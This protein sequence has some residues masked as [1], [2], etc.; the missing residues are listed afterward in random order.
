[1]TCR[2][3][4]A[5]YHRKVRRQ[6]SPFAFVAVM[7]LV[8]PALIASQQPAV[9]IGVFRDL[10]WRLLGPFRG[11]RTTTIAGV[12]SQPHTFYAGTANGGVWRTTDAGATW[13]PIFDG[14]T[15]GSIG[16]I[17][18]APSDPNVIYVGTGASPIHD[19]AS[20][21]D[22]LYRSSD[23]GRSWSRLGLAGEPH[24]SGIIVDPRSPDRVL[25]ASAGGARTQSGQRG[26]Y[27]STNG[28]KSFE[29]VFVSDD[30]IGALDLAFD[31]G[32]SSIVY[33]TL[34]RRS[35]N[36]SRTSAASKAAGVIKSSDGGTTWSPASAGLPSFETDALR[37]VRL[38]TTVANR[39]RLYAVADA[40]DRSGVYRTDDGAGT[41]TRVHPLPASTGASGSRALAV[42]PANAD[43]V[44]LLGPEPLRSIDAGRSFGPWPWDP[45]AGALHAVWISPQQPPLIAA[46]GEHGA[47]VTLNSGETWSS[48]HNQPTGRFVDV[49]ADNAF[50]YRVCATS[51]VSPPGCLPSR[52][53]GGRIVA[54]DWRAVS[55]SIAGAVAPD[56]QDADLVYTGS[57][58]RFDRRTGQSQH[59]APVAEPGDRPHPTP[60]LVFGANRTL[61]YGS[62]RL[63]R[64]AA[65]QNWA[66]ASPDLTRGQ[67]G[68]ITT[69]APSSIDGRLVWVGTD[70]GQVHVT[71]DG[72]LMWF[73]RTPDDLAPGARVDA[74]EPSHFDG[75]TAYVAAS[76]SASRSG[77]LWRTRDGGISW[78]TI[79]SGLPQ[80]AV[81]HAI[82]EDGLRRGLLFAA[83]TRSIF[84]S[85]D[86][87]GRWQ[88]FR[89]N[90]PPAPV[91]GLTIKESDLVAATDGRGLW[92]L[93]DISPLRQIT[94]DVA[95]VDL[96]LFRP[97]TGWRTPPT[98]AL[99]PSAPR[100]EPAA[101]NP[102]DG[103]ALSYYN[104]A[105]IDAPV[106]EIVET[107]TGDVIRRFENLPGGA[108]FHR[109]F[110]DLKY[111][112]T[113]GRAVWVLP[114]TYQVR[115][116]AGPR[117][118][119]QAVVVR[120]DPR[121]RATAA[122]LTAQLKLSR[123]VDD[124]RRQIAAIL[125]TPG[126]S[127]TDVRQALADAATE[128]DRVIDLLQ[129]ADA[130][131]TAPAEAAAAAAMA[132]GD[133]ALASAR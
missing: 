75:N 71:R 55:P 44:Y 104:S 133:A 29:R 125:A 30:D 2:S 80:D 128:L 127:Q 100:D 20:S 40:G 53:A 82:R 86:D 15:T 39:L 21:G 98:S 1:M 26:I 117:V 13:R 37:H 112:P 97:A 99:D 43:I 108:G 123:A 79:T 96:F 129:S 83:T 77:Q 4:G 5:D 122:D 130:R 27:R 120:I 12:S 93:D 121:V 92:V 69:I 32:N 89:L 63:W 56:P 87:G 132:R 7:L 94:A 88:S 126:G 24:L 38:A 41:W 42:D 45:A 14:E 74:I 54:G 114:G 109:M 115:L 6:A 33:A 59:F 95:R 72:G 103:V 19:G 60:P 50:P 85:F 35:R 101:E 51:R 28:G 64:M 57:L 106:L 62:N 81:V 17:A 34:I 31:A 23:G 67:G 11:G 73:T 58:Q 18:I 47:R 102:P 113:N 61:Y 49:V 52:G 68:L 111:A 10:T 36:D 3:R 22:G 70:D 84:V 116:T 119:R 65:G 78:Q 46:A 25:V 105:P 76:G 118:A 9:D 90:L 48:T 91:T 16:S 8:I 107:I 66:A 110:W 124:R 131:P